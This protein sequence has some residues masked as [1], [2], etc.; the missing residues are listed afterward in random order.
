V[1]RVVVDIASIERV[2]VAAVVTVGMMEG[3]AVC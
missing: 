2:V 1:Q 3:M